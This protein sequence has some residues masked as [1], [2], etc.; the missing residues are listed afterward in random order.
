MGSGLLLAEEPVLFNISDEPTS[1]WH[2]D[3]SWSAKERVPGMIGDFF[4]GTSTALRGNFSLDRLMVPVNDLDSPNP[5]PPGGSL[6]TITEPGPVGIFS[7][8]VSSI[9]EIQQLLR[10]SSPFPG[11]TQVGSINANGTMTTTLTISQIQALLA[12]TPQPYDIVPL[13]APPA[14]YQTGVDQAFQARNAITGT[15]Q[16]NAAAS[17]A[18]LQGGVDTLAGGEDFD[19]FYIYDYNAAINITTP[20]AGSGGLGFAKIAEGGSPIPHDRVFFNY[21]NY[22]S[23]PYGYGGSNLYSYTPGFEKTFFDGM[24]S[25]EVRV[26]FASGLNPNL[27]TNG[28][29]LTNSGGTKF[30]NVAL[31][32]KVL[33]H[34]TQ[35]YAFSAGLGV[36]LPTADGTSVALSNGTPLL[37]IKNEAVHLQPFLGLVYAPNDRFFTQ[38]FVQYDLAANGNPVALNTGTALRNAG[39]LTDANHIFVDLGLGYWLYRNDCECACGITGIAPMFEL[40]YT[41]TISDSD[42][43]SA[44]PF[45]VGDFNGDLNMVNCVAG[46][47]IGFANGGN[48]SVAYTGPLTDDRQFD[49]G[50]RVLY[51]QSYGW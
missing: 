2:G 5:L 47:T 19:A 37:N 46:A 16:F 24:A 41:G 3:A 4:G 50:L 15:T 12:S 43:V 17:G 42:I 14:A 31:Y 36:T 8:S 38:G 13:A 32:S 33:L 10:A 1:Y 34:Q 6:L 48:L 45:Q 27:I 21:G 18:I 44:G 22:N 7:T 35:S 9:Q 11:A 40:H 30:G 49:G 26:P 28:S 39:T 51:S 29:A 25:V 20:A 23:V